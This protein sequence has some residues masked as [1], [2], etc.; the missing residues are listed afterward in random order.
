MKR[1][2]ER[3]RSS[4]LVRRQ[5]I[6]EDPG[7]SQHERSGQRKGASEENIREEMA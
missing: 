4:G 6:K 7:H 5:R 2:W 1:V 3:M